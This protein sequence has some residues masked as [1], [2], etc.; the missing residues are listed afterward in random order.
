MQ[1]IPPQQ[2]DEQSNMDKLQKALYAREESSDLKQRQQDIAHFGRRE[3]TVSEDEAETGPAT[4]F[5]DVIAQRTK[6]RNS[7][8]LWVSIAV[9]SVLVVAAAVGGTLWYRSALQV[10][11][12][13]MDISLTAPQ[14]FTSGEEAT[15][16]I[17]YKNKSRMKWLNVE[18]TFQPPA[19]FAYHSSS[20]PAEPSGPQY[21]LRLGDINP[22]VAGQVTLTGQ[23]LG[24]Q[25]SISSGSVEMAVSPANFPNERLK[26]TATADTT[27][28]ALPVELSVEM[29]DAAAPGDRVLGVVHV[30][31]VSTQTLAHAYIKLD[32]PPGVDVAK[33]DADFSPDFSVTDSLWLLPPLEPLAEATRSMIV[34]IQGDPGEHREIKVEAGVQEGTNF[35]AQQ[36]VSHVVTVTA[37]QLL[38][39]QTYNKSSTDQ[40]V[41]AGQQIEGVV[42]YKNVGT[43]GLKDV[44]VTVKFDGT[45]ID[46]ATLKLKNGAYSP[47]TRTITWSAASVPSLATLLPQQEGDLSYTFNMLTVDKLPTGDKAKN[48]RLVTTATIDSPNLPTPVG[49]ERKVITDQL[50]LSL[51]TNLTLGLDA[52]YDDGR[53]GITS[54]GPLPPKVGEQTTY[55]LRMRLGSTINDVENAHVSLVLPDGVSYT[56]KNYVTAGT[57]DFNSRTGE[58]TW[59]IP[60]LNGL[61]G[62]TSP[63]EELDVQ[64][65]ITPGENTRGEEVVLAKA[66][67]AQGTDSFTNDPISIQ[68]TD[69]PTTA[70]ADKDKG[71]VE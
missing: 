64:V 43:V 8:I 24:Q 47:T 5:V 57:T 18:L 50:V 1:P 44:I 16:T 32:V 66:L 56:G 15:Y 6:K 27:I 19:G 51:T 9:G 58:I 33:E 26:K 68:V 46:P 7:W 3:V 23:L 40:N 55:T 35:I 60:L 4:S 29:G 54:S 62:R 61:T 53:L 49:Q 38:I 2:P 48:L 37:P 59:N 13:L 30:R 70:T 28:T 39:S 65:A 34:Y 67:S 14:T 36:N 41:L 12:A 21:L 45:G 69:M 22:N 10:T 42:H 20:I 71:K 31:N 63:A 25:Q 11:P 17:N 52:F